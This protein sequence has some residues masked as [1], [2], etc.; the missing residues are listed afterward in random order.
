MAVIYNVYV[1]YYV[2]YSSSIIF[3]TLPTPPGVVARAASRVFA[4][5]LKRTAD[6]STLCQR[7]LLIACSGTGWWLKHRRDTGRSV[8]H[9]WWQLFPTHNELGMV[10]AICEG[11]WHQHLTSGGN[12]D[13]RLSHSQ[14]AARRPLFSL[15]LLCRLKYSV[16]EVQQLLYM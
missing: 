14:R 9:V 2:I 6:V 8:L 7:I 1:Y 5:V 12:S 3:P 13:S 4:I 10:V 11:H 15:G 16:V